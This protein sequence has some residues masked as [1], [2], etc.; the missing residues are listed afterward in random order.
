MLQIN[1][2]ITSSQKKINLGQEDKELEG[3]DLIE[4]QKKSWEKFVK[5]ELKEIFNE[6]FPIDDYTGKKFTLFFNDIS[7]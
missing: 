5:L 6:F 3:Y 7:R 2:S 1:S 4:I